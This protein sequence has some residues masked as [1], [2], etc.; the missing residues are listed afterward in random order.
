MTPLLEIN[1]LEVRY[2]RTRAVSELNL[3]V[4]AGEAVG[5]IGPNGAGKT[6]TLN[7]IAGLLRPTA[8]TIVFDGHDAVGRAPE[9]LVRR[10]LALVPEGRQIFTSLTVHE[11]LRLPTFAGRTKDADG[12]IERELERFPVL[13]TYLKA[14]AGGLSG[15]EQ[16]MLAISR[17]LLC[18]PKLLLLDEP[19]LGLAPKMVDVVFAALEGLRAEGVTVLLVEQNAARTLAFAERTYVLSNGSIEA[20]G[21]GD[22]LRR[23]ERIER[24]YLGVGRP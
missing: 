1:G 7:A 15:G 16:Q 3:H 12:D 22:E 11:N 18:R 9:R 4:E 19:S 6:T 23:D 24:A 17:A 10:G 13:R 8:G 14:H 20:H 5:L 2:G 21:T